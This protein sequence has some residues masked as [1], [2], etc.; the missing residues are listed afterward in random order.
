LLLVL[1]CF[2][3]T[4]ESLAKSGFINERPHTEETQYEQKK[5]KT[6]NHNR[7]LKKKA[8]T[9]HTTP[10]KMNYVIE[11][12]LSVL[13]MLGWALL[14]VFLVRIMVSEEHQMLLGQVEETFDTQW[15][16]N[17]LHTGDVIMTFGPRHE[18]TNFFHGHSV[19]H[20][21]VVFELEP[22]EAYEPKLVFEVRKRCREERDL[23]FVTLRSY[24]DIYATSG[25]SFLVRRLEKPLDSVEFAT[26]LIWFRSCVWR[27][28]VSVEQ[29]NT[30]AETVP[31]LP[32]LPQRCTTPNALYCSQAAAVAL[33]AI[34]VLDPRV[35][36]ETHR[37]LTPVEFALPPELSNLHYPLAS[38]VMAPHRWRSLVQVVSPETLAIQLA[39]QQGDLLKAH[40]MMQALKEVQMKNK[41]TAVREHKQRKM[42]SRKL[43]KYRGQAEALEARLAELRAF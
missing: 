29:I 22:D 39:K 40:K 24:F 15:A 20:C 25:N 35:L 4:F 34:G 12:T 23:G 37:V 10:M 42:L 9:Q 6:Q 18:G 16:M 32:L 14:L 13:F 19:T 3:F 21:A 30:W 11:I 43:V 38:N 17:N 2:F 1:I 28:T 33:V 41:M 31:C 36:S 27:D 7:K 8:K 26:K 5:K